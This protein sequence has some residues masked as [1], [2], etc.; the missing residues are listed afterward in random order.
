MKRRTF[1]T[2]IGGA[3]AWPLAAGAQQAAVPVI[4]YLESRSPDGMTDRLRAFRQG[5]KDTGYVERENVTIEYRWADN[6]LD[7]LP[8]LAA[9]LVRRQVARD[10][11]ARRPS[12]SGW[13]PS[14]QLLRFPSSS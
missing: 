8:A 13:R 3:A 12:A 6:Q 1:I 7:R 2:L 5:L 11:C 14:R 4:G 10:R 9:E